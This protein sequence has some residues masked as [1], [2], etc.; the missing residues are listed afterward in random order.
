[1]KILKIFGIVVGIHVFAL[2]LIFA[3][4]GCSSSSKQP[5]LTDASSESPATP[6]SATST[7]VTPAPAP[8]VN[9]TSVTDDGLL[10][11]PDSLTLPRGSFALAEIPVNYASLSISNPT[12]GQLWRTHARTMF[13][14]LIE[15]S[16][17]VVTDFLRDTLDG[18]ERAFYLLSYNGPNFDNSSGALN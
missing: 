8:V 9:P 6:A 18:R 2:L 10:L 7:T 12:L 5:G 14:R 4:P 11:P 3:N 15:E 16:G 13:K 1:M 17:Y